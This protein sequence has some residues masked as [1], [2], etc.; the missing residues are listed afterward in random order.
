M[1]LY[2]DDGRCQYSYTYVNS[3][4][5]DWAVCEIEPLCGYVWEIGVGDI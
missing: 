4:K 3:L 2:I 5:L 1:R